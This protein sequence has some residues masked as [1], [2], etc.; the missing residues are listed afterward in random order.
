MDQIKTLLDASKTDFK[1]LHRQFRWAIPDRFNMARSVCDRHA[2]GRER[3]ALQCVSERGWSKD[4]TFDDLRRLSNQ[5]ANVLSLVWASSRAIGSRFFCRSVLRQD[6][7]I[8]RPENWRAVVTLS[9][10]FGIDALKYRLE[11]SGARAVITTAAAT[12]QLVE[13]GKEL[14]E[15]EFIIDCDDLTSGFWP[16]L[17][18]A[19][20]Q[21]NPVDTLADDPALVIYTSG[22][23][24]PPKGAVLAH[25][26]LLGNLPGLSCLKIFPTSE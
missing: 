9:I 4:Y 24:G 15:L 23:T 2:D 11:D 25:R 3:V 6:L 21:L 19:S 5:L 22:T 26:C 16:L 8:W 17:D 12:E 13:L 18:K 10:L 7:R 14:P 20:D 1:D